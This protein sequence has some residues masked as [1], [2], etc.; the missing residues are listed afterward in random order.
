M[1]VYWTEFALNSLREIYTYHKIHAGTSIANKIKLKIFTSTGQ[2]A[3]HPYS[4]SPETLLNIKDIDYRYVISGNY[5]IIYKVHSSIIYI[6]DIFDCR[7]DPDKI[8]SRNQDDDLI[9]EPGSQY[10]TSD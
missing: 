2:L 6:T 3:H 1:K 4:G 8:P 9:N 5:K 7:Q 10:R